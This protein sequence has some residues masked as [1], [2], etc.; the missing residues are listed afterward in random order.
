MRYWRSR[1]STC[2]QKCNAKLIISKAHRT[3]STLR[4]GH[5]PAPPDVSSSWFIR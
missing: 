3:R 5:R 4:Q 2:L 1:I